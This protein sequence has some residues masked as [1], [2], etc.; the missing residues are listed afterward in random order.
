MIIMKLWAF[1]MREMRGDEKS[2]G[3]G[4]A[5][6]STRACWAADSKIWSAQGTI[7]IEI[8]DGRLRLK[9][10]C[11]ESVRVVVA[12]LDYVSAELKRYIREFAFR[13]PDL[14]L[15]RPTRRRSCAR[16]LSR[17]IRASGS[18]HRLPADLSSWRVIA[19]MAALQDPL[20]T[21]DP[22]APGSQNDTL[23]L[24]EDTFPHPVALP[25]ALSLESP[26][27]SCEDG[28]ISLGFPFSQPEELLTLDTDMPRSVGLGA[29]PQ[30]TRW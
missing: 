18:L 23:A 21:L 13:L 27:P 11:V 19:A 6:N 26:S 3:A 30:W 8:P 5:S 24:T 12:R 14:P 28:G 2:T 25:E 15:L 1:S 4:R 9:L 16:A 22:F 29:G 10:V 7:E 17:A 20:E